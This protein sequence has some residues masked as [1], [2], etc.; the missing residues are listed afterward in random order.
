[1]SIPEVHIGHVRQEISQMEY[2]GHLSDAIFNMRIRNIEHELTCLERFID[3]Q[4][5]RQNE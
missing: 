2:D 4:E 3:E 1:M 5:G